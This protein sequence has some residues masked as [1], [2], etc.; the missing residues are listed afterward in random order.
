MA[1]M[2]SKAAFI[3]V[4]LLAGA[5]GVPQNSISQTPAASTACS[6][7]QAEISVGDGYYQNQCGCLENTAV[8]VPPAQLTCTVPSGT[9][10]IFLFLV[11][12]MKH[13]VLSIGITPFASSPLSD[14]TQDLPTRI[15][16]FQFIKSGTYS[17]VDTFNSTMAGQIVVP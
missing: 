10:V 15:Y 6:S 5:C 16:A 17:F 13:Q 3:A 2:F 8:V 12:N 4:F 1:L 14:P 9:Q 7:G 11:E